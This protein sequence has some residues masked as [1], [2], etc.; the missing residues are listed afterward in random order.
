M[1]LSLPFACCHGLHV[2]QKSALVPGGCAGIEES[3]SEAYGIRNDSGAY[4]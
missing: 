1:C 3:E 4:L 2:S